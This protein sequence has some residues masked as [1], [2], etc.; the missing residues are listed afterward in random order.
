MDK[1]KWL[2][3]LCFAVKEVTANIT[4]TLIARSFLSRYTP[5]SF[6]T[7]LSLCLVIN[8]SVKASWQQP[9]GKQDDTC[10]HTQSHTNT[11]TRLESTQVSCSA[12]ILT[13]QYREDILCLFLSLLAVMRLLIQLS[14]AALH[15]NMR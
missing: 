11:N 3:F 4:S 14:P 8:L 12:Q 13:K 15:A 10:V 9:E 6:I 5:S 1:V 2:S 7:F